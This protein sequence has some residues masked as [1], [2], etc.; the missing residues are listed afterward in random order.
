MAGR[1]LIVLVGPTAV[2]KTQW[3]IRL[4]KHYNSEVVSSDSRQVYKEMAIGTAVPSEKEL[5][6]VPHHLIQHRSIK[7]PYSVG[8]FVKEA[9]A[10][11]EE[12]FEKHEIVIMT[13]GS[14]LYIQALLF[15]LDEFPDIDPQIRA[16]L[17]SIRKS[18]GL[19]E[20]QLMLKKED[21]DYYEQVDL[22]NPHRIIRALEV[23]LG[24]NRPYSSYL[25]KKNMQLTFDF[26][27][28]G[29]EMDRELLYSRINKRVDEMLSAG[30]FNEVKKLQ[31]HKHIYALQTVGYK[32]L[33]KHLHGVF[34][35]ETAVEEIKKNTRRF[36]K[37]QGTWFRKMPGIVWIPW[38]TPEN[39]FIDKVENLIQR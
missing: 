36:A 12:L 33:F 10:L 16:D 17:N 30:L 24:T 39:E 25:G 6:Q 19:H 2:G 29:L 38:N 26:S 20:L 28:I 11:L 21:P 18:K 1:H 15:G 13:G 22:E 7:D 34:S 32:E 3:A 5:Q 4:A 23:C 27:L 31:D 8:D 9:K 14:G 35:L 37:R